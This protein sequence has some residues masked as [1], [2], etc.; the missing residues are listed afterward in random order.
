MNPVLI[1]GIGALLVGGY[2]TSSDMAQSG[3]MYYNV[4]PDVYVNNTYYGGNGSDTFGPNVSAVGSCD[5][6]QKLYLSGGNLACD[7]DLTGG[8]SGTNYWVDGG[9]YLYPNSTFADNVYGHMINASIWYNASITDWDVQMN[10]YPAACG[11]GQYATTVGD[12]LTCSSPA[13]LG[14]M[15]GTTPWAWANVTKPGDC[16]GGQ[17][18]TGIDGASLECGSPG[19]SGN[20]TGDGAIGMFAVWK[21]TG[22]IGVNTTGFYSSTMIDTFN[23][24]MKGYVD[25][26]DTAYNTSMDTFVKAYVGA[27]NTSMKAY[28]NGMDT[29]VNSSAT[30]YSTAVDTATNTTMKAYVD[31]KVFADAQVN[32]AIT[33]YTNT[34]IT[35]TSPG[36]LT[37]YT[38]M[39]IGGPSGWKMYVN[40]TGYLVAEDV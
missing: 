13:S 10:N 1:L 7:T 6:S 32:D 27:E 4:D 37:I 5:S 15:T 2:L 9:A 35:I 26:K 31:G 12:T 30:T 11:A 40:G 29:A 16:A 33:V 8:G 3:Q 19:G 14:Y 20:I 38:T 17:Y 18:V 36:N 21:T 34:N 22:F 23:T 25:G 24:S 39:Y 28:V